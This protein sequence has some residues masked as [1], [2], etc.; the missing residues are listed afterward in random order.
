[1]RVKEILSQGRETLTAN[2][3]EDAGL[4]AEVLLRHALSVNRVQ[5]YLQQDRELSAEEN[6]NFRQSMRR[7]L[8]NE[9]TAYITGHREF[10]GRDIYVDDN[11][12]IPRP[13]TELLVETALGLAANRPIHTIADIGT[14][15]GAI[16][17]SLALS[18]PQ[19]R[20]YA[21]DISP[22]ALRVAQ[23]N[24]RK[25]G[26]TDVLRLLQGDL[27]DP[28]PE[29]ADLIVANLPYVREEELSRVNTWHFEPSTA[30]NGGYDGLDTIRRLGAQVD[31]KLRSGGGL[32]L[33]IGLA[34]GEAVTAFFRELFP[35]A[36]IK[37][38]PDGNG[39]DR[40]VSLLTA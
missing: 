40:V 26:V 12:L 11:V 23:I 18:L 6:E 39:I 19:T 14:G 33:E 22:A 27:L 36:E 31:G 24:S 21:T 1:M 4:E 38:I 25:H 32:L 37:L 15:S 10:Y 29:P 9:P 13:E 20:I 8:N 34:Q 7:R 35:S 3:I 16:A 30:L 5:L 28:L 17:I 2:R